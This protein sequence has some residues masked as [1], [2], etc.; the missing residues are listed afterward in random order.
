MAF[1]M[2]RWLLRAERGSQSPARSSSSIE[3]RIRLAAYTS[4]WVPWVSSNRL[5]ASI[6]P[7]MPAWIMSSS[8]TLAGS[9]AIIWCA[10]RRTSGAYCFA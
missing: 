8:S 9:L 4:N 3:P 5:T 1:S 6:R 10:M 7:I 2:S